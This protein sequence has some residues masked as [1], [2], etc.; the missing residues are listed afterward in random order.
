MLLYPEAGLALDEVAARVVEELQAGPR[1]DEL[2][3]R[4]MARHAGADEQQV[5]RDTRTFL[6]ALRARGLLLVETSPP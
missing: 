4:L 5:D 6:D 2:V 3:A 1:L